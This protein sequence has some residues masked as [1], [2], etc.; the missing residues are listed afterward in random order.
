[1]FTRHTHTQM[2]ISP[3]EN[4]IEAMVGKNKELVAM[5]EKYETS[6][7]VNASPFTMALNGVIDAAVNGGTEMYKKAFFAKSYLVS[8]PEHAEFVKT[9]KASL[10][11]QINI[12]QR[13]MILHNR[14]CSEEMRALHSKMETFFADLKEKHSR[15]LDEN[16]V[17]I[18]VATSSAP[19]SPPEVRKPI[20][21]ARTESVRHPTV[22][23]ETEH[24]KAPLTASKS[25]DEMD[26]TRPPKPAKPLPGAKPVFPL[27]PP[28]SAN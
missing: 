6:T 23:A 21:M 22:S 18:G 27:K 10:D 12:L 28:N 5:I 7:G 24:Q 2:E 8:Y 25:M 16:G 9:L 4:A 11:D 15:P 17:A 20:P 19:S 1:M 13:G 3:I 14:V 26:S